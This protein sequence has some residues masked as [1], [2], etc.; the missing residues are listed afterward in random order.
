MTLLFQILNKILH[1]FSSTVLV[2]FLSTVPFTL[3]LKTLLVLY[4]SNFSD[5]LI[6]FFH[7]LFLTVSF[8]RSLLHTVCRCSWPSFTIS[9][10]PLSFKP[11]KSLLSNQ[12]FF[13]IY[14][15]FREWYGNPSF[16]TVSTPLL[17]FPGSTFSQEMSH[18]EGTSKFPFPSM[19]YP[20]GV[21]SSEVCITP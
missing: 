14:S 5:V 18:S 2:T 20:H 13:I 8:R 3:R 1:S 10:Y 11:E 19:T 9:E 7:G 6:T 12:S 4:T 21:D 15:T 17:Y 16:H